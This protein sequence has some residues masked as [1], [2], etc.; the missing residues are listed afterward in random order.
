MPPQ[1]KVPNRLSPSGASDNGLGAWVPWQLAEAVIRLDLRPPSRGRVFLAIFF[2]WCR[3]G[4]GE[5][6]L[7]VSKITEMTGLSKRSVQGA[8][9]ALIEQELITRIGRNGRIRVTLRKLESDTSGASLPA[10]PRLGQASQRSADIS[11][12]PTRRQA[13]ASPTVFMSSTLVDINTDTFTKK[14]FAFITD[15]LREA[16]ELMGSDVGGLIMDDRHTAELRLVAPVTYAEA[17]KA[18]VTSKNKAMARDFTKAILALRHDER[19]QGIELN[20]SGPRAI[21]PK[22]QQRPP[23]PQS[24]PPIAAT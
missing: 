14:Q 21:E 3:Y 6:H 20:T 24:S 8:I 13:C 11:A 2:T 5:A 10:S 16:F 17:L 4:Q 7:T 15:V 23:S 9:T 18:V 19:V 22:W 12:L 1:P